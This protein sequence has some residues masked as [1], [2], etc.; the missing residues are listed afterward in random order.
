M[1]DGDI[2]RRERSREH[3]IVGSVDRRVLAN[4]VPSAESLLVAALTLFNESDD[5]DAT[6]RTTLT[7]LTSALNGRIGEV[8][9]RGGPARDVALSYSSSDGTPLVVAFEAEGKALGL[10]AGPALVSRV[11]KS[12]RGSPRASVIADGRGGRVAEAAAADIHSA[13]TFPIRGREGLVGVL[14]VFRESTVESNRVAMAA[15]PGI[16]SHLGRFIER[17]RAETAIHAAAM[18]LAALAST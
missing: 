7:M 5:L 16:C 13:M 8:W 17:V 12:G 18:E 4:A 10:G 9:L 2:R 15:M 14:V 1:L 3:V 6:L 11:V